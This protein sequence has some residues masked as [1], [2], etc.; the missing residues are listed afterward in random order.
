MLKIAAAACSARLADGLRLFEGLAIALAVGDLSLTIRSGETLALV[1]ESGCGKTTAALSI[2]RLVASPGPGLV[3]AELRPIEEPALEVLVCAREPPDGL[4]AG[5]VVL[6][7]AGS[8][9]AVVER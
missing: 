4:A 2:M 8:G 9:L 3:V 7:R 1:G 6:Y 5:R